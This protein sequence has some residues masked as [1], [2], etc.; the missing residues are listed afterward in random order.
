MVRNEPL[1]IDIIDNVDFYYVI[2][3]IP[4][5]NPADIEVKGGENYIVVK[6]KKLKEKFKNYILMERFSGKF[7]RKINFPENINIE[8]AQA[9]YRNGVLYIKIPKLKN[10]IF[11]DTSVKIN[12]IFRR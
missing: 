12:I 10:E 11:I 5:I 3:D 4:G 1:P 2:M 8:K 6:G 9:E 7:L